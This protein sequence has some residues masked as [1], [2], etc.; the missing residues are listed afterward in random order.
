[1]CLFVCVSLISNVTQSEVSIITRCSLIFQFRFDFTSFS[2][3]LRGRKPTKKEH[4]NKG[5][6]TGD[7]RYT[8]VPSVVTLPFPSALPIEIICVS[9]IRMASHHMQ[10]S[11]LF[12]TPSTIGLIQLAQKFRER[13]STVVT[14]YGKFNN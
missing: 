3:L 11:F 10:M 7:G 9:L 1:M 13:Q 12:E 2:R 5:K 14:V 4:G 6:V 8:E